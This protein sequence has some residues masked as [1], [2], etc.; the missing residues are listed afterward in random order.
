MN[1]FQKMLQKINDEKVKIE[2]EREYIFSVGKK[3]AE[4]LQSIKSN[5]FYTKYGK[6]LMRLLEKTAEKTLDILNEFDNEYDILDNIKGDS[7]NE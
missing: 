6:R 7:E 1:K 5:Q 4:Q 2:K 3:T